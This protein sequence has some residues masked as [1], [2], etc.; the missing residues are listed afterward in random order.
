MAGRGIRG[1][2]TGDSTSLATGSLLFDHSFRIRG[3][4]LRRDQPWRRGCG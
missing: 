3:E 2:E 4:V 1:R